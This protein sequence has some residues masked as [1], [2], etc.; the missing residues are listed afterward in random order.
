MKIIIILAYVC[1]QI[2]RGFWGQKKKKK[3]EQN[4]DMHL[5]VWGQQYDVIT[6]PHYIWQR[7][8]VLGNNYCVCWAKV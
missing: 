5:T 8:A 4:C 7:F 3:N 1:L 6:K 2:C